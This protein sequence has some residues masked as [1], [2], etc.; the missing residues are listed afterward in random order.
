MIEPPEQDLRR[1]WLA[2]S[3]L[4]DERPRVYRGGSIN[5]FARYL[6]CAN[7]ERARPGSRWYNVG[8]RCAKDPP[9]EKE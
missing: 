8:F 3:E 2:A 5:S 6:R 9:G 7:R 1:R 4:D